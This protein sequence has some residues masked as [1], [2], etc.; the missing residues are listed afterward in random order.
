MLHE[1]AQ[2]PGVLDRKTFPLSLVRFLFAVIAAAFLIATLRIEGAAPQDSAAWRRLFD[3]WKAPCDPFRI[4]GNVHYVGA[5][6]VSAFLISTP[7]GH[8]LL[9]TG[10]EETV[11]VI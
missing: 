1:V 10:F 3:S 2:R 5:S 9:D 4:V 6:G 11:G 7:E 8:I